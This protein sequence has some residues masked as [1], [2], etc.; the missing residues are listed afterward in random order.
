MSPGSQQDTEGFQLAPGSFHGF[1]VA[2]HIQALHL[3]QQELRA[4]GFGLGAHSLGQLR[5]AGA[6]DAGVIH[7]FVGNGD[8]AAEFFFLDHDH[9]VFG[10]CQVQCGSQAR[11]PAAD[12]HNVI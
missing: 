8:L 7:D 2:F 6:F 1:E 5:A 11:R 3:R 12:D 10:S 4:E 9:A